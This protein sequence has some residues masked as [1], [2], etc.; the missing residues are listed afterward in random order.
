ME[1]DDSPWA[2]VDPAGLHPVTDPAQARIV[3]DPTRSRFLH[4]FLGR[5]RTV[6]E[7]AAELGCAADVMLYR[8]RRMLAASLLRITAT[9]RRTGRPIKVYRSSHDGYFVP[10]DAMHYDDLRH[11]VSSQG[12]RL[13]EELVDAYTAVLFGA[14]NEGRVLARNHLGEVWSTDLTPAMNSRG[15]PVLMTDIRR[16]LTVD[17]AAQIRQLLT[18]AI[19]SARRVASTP[20]EAGVSRSRYLLSCSLLPISNPP[21]DRDRSR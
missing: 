20:A 6:S 7:A 8:V 16:D 12:A 19:N 4:P 11:R 17:E 14:G 13:V 10:N 18:A 9:R 1:E 15:E 3:A 2:G 5:E 21:H